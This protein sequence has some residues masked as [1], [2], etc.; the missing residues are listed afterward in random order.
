MRAAMTQRQRAKKGDGDV[1]GALAAHGR[2]VPEGDVAHD[3][4]QRCVVE[5]REDERARQLVLADCQRERL[6]YFQVDV[7]ER[8]SLGRGFFVRRRMRR[9]DL[10]LQRVELEIVPR[11]LATLDL[12]RDRKCGLDAAV[13]LRAEAER[14]S[15]LAPSS[16]SRATEGPTDR[17]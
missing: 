11:A 13:I 3:A 9:E 12:L 2:V 17:G 6:Q 5:P 8:E 1:V 4:R 7:D 14:Q 15:G 16:S 10:A